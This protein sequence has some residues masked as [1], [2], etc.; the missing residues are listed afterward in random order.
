MLLAGLDLV[1]QKPKPPGED[2]R[3]VNSPVLSFLALERFN[4]IKLV[5]FVH[6]SLAAI[7]RV[8]TSPS[9]YS[10]HHSASAALQ[11]YPYC[12][13]LS[14]LFRCTQL[15]RGKQLLT[16][17]LQQLA[18]ELMAQETPMTWSDRTPG[19]D[20]PLEYLRA[21]ISRT[22]AVQQWAQ[23]AE[24]GVLFNA[25]LDLSDLF[26]PATF[27]NAFRQ[28]VALEL[29]LPMDSLRLQCSW[30]GDGGGGARGASLLRI[31][32]LQLEGATFNGSALTDNA[33]DAPVTSAM[34]NC[35]VTWVQS[36]A[37]AEDTSGATLT[38]PVYFDRRRARLVVEVD[39]PCGGNQA[40]WIQ[41]GVALFLRAR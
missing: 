36:D 22:V 31:A 1:Q 3:T 34:P 32:G 5:Q 11:S 14:C 13:D 37:R 28:Q 30:R 12:L 33:H 17:E 25:P 39:F 9:N 27:L 16:N 18:T 23:Q 29:R 19:P 38:L 41:S 21:L 6:N 10:S 26:N 20:D 15:L 8:R 40:V 24:Q 2:A 7:S 4:A 35:T